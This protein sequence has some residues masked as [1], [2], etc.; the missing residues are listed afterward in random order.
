MNTSR[1]PEE[2]ASAGKKSSRPQPAHAAKVPPM[3]N[4]MARA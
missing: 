3:R 2:I 1:R 4:L